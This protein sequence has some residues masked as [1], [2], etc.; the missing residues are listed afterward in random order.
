MPAENYYRAVHIVSECVYF[1]LSERIYAVS[2]HDK[3]VAMHNA[4]MNRLL[5]ENSGPQMTEK[6]WQLFD[7]R[8]FGITAKF[9]ISVLL[10][11]HQY[12]TKGSSA[13]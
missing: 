4:M 2:K 5:S 10:S 6:S 13:C 12:H 7:R 11:A 1:L 9:W 8:C 3:N